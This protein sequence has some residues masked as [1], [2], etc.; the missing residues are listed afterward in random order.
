MRPGQAR[1]VTACQQLL[2][3]AVVFAVLTPAASVI[4]LD[5]VGHDGAPLGGGG[6][7]SSRGQHAGRLASSVPTAPV[8][9]VV[10]EFALTPPA[11]ART[12]R[13]APTGLLSRSTLGA[14][15]RVR[16]VGTPEPVHGYGSVGVSWAGAAPAEQDLS[17]SVRTLTGEDWSDWETVPYEPEHGPDPGSEE[18][19]HARPGTDPL[20]VGDVDQVQVRVDAAPG[21]TPDD[22][23]LAVIDPGT[24]TDSRRELPA[25]D[26][27][28]L[29]APSTSTPG[30]PTTADEP[31]RETSDGGDG[32]AALQA[33]TYTPK[34]KIFSRAQWGAD[35]SIREKSALHYYE[36]HAGFVHHTVNAN[37]YTRAEVPA[38]IRG[39]YAYHV[40]VRGW[41]D[42][43]YNFL[44]DRFGR[45]W[46]GRYGGVDRPVVGAHTLGYNDYSFAM[47]AIG[48]YETTRPSQAVLKAY[49]RLFAW[50]LSLH[51]VD[52]SSTHQQV[53]PTVFRAI[54]GHRDAAATACPGKYLYAKLPT[55]RQYAKADQESWSGR[56]R[57]TN[58]ASSAFPD[59]VV[60]RASDGRVFVVPTGGTTKFRAPAAV[61]GLS[62]TALGASPAHVVASA[63]L[64]GDGVSDLAVLDDS[65]RL[66]VLPG[67]RSGS[68]GAPVRRNR[69]F[70]GRDLLTSPGDLDEDGH[71]DLVA[72][73]PSTGALNFYRGDGTGRFTRIGIGGDW[74]GYTLLSGAGDLDG[75]GHLDL[76]AKAAGQLWLLP[77]NGH[78]RFGTAVALPGDRSSVNALL[79]FGD[80]T[81]DGRA[82]L[83]VRDSTTGAGAILPAK[84][85]GTYGR[86]IGSVMRFKGVADLSAADL[87]GTKQIDAIGR[88]KGSYV[89]MRH[90][91]TFET[92]APIAT[93][94][95]LRGATML[96]NVGDWDRDGFGDV[97]VRNGSDGNL[98][99]RRGK[100]NGRFGAPQQVGTGFGNVK[101]LAAVG[102]MTGDGYP[103]L[104]GQPSGG[105]MRIYPGAGLNGLRPSYVAYGGISA[106]RQIGVGRWN[107]D[108]APDSLLRKGS[109]L[110]LYPGN[111]PGGLVSKVRTFGLDLSPY[112]WV[113][114]VGDAQRNGHAD[115]VVREKAT[116]DL[117]LL[118][119]TSTGFASRIY[120][121][122]GFGGYDLAG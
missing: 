34:P 89:L 86:P 84:A 21:T 22:M 23:R 54:N 26:T 32:T 118:P 43:G 45:I 42:I 27:A 49:G 36:V 65:G 62:S 3:L 35:E 99:L 71:N 73:N 41:S 114:G 83:L 4:S 24:A 52:A 78:G 98:Y 112:D 30:S 82:D 9:A 76:V 120:L 77:G 7:G 88:K 53:G 72:R 47:S 69:L 12:A 31:A 15:G 60:R 80:L 40:R 81:H 110:K 90:A 67:D 93:G 113:L 74:S 119:G 48:N 104:M 109:T 5:V 58:L 13:T 95:R 39:I 38:L 102:D 17:I 19:K 107:G 57:V 91:G 14:S 16:L 2:A 25:I 92:G 96:L 6:Q 70:A 97:I 117:Y 108:G 105:A 106:G 46:E 85:D 122:S 121:G 50:K 59:L 10:R 55:I 63:D 51:G 11:G 29:D 33:T 94:M 66:S 20:L 111:G 64:T 101:L 75:D 37:S 28:T 1:F 8:D 18:A 87:S 79:G 44:V 115:L 68:F 103:D 116:G 56:N 100:G 61:G